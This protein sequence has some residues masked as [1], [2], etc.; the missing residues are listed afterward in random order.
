MSNTKW[1]YTQLPLDEMDLYDDYTFR[2]RL[3]MA[4]DAEWELV[5]ILLVRPC[6]YMAIFKRPKQGNKQGG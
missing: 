4:G 2:V 3:N 6:E 5:Q 1:E